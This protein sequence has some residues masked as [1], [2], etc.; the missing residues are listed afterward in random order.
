MLVWAVLT[1][2]D[3]Q[4]CE[5]HYIYNAPTKVLFKIS[6]MERLIYKYDY[7]RPLGGTPVKIFFMTLQKWLFV[8]EVA[9]VKQER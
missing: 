1:E 2:K 4:I 7:Y 8:A 3:L 5:L 6:Q 9:M